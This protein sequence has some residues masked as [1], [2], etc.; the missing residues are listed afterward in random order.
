MPAFGDVEL[1]DLTPLR[2]KTFVAR[3]AAKRKPTTVRHVHALLST[4]LN[5]AVAEGPC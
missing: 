4:I 5:D 2:I 3:L 1:K